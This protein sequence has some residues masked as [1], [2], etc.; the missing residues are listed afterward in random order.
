V[1]SSESA[2]GSITRYCGHCGQCL[3]LPTHDL[4]RSFRCPRCQAV[5]VAGA[6]IDP[7]TPI[8]AVPASDRMPMAAEVVVESP[9][10]TPKAA[11]DGNVAARL[12]GGAALA[13]LTAGRLVTLADRIDSFLYGKRLRL[14]VVAAAAVVGTASLSDGELGWLAPLAL[15]AFVA[16]GAVLTLAR[17]AMFRDD[18]GRWAPAAGWFNFICAVTELGDNV[19]LLLTATVAQRLQAAGTCLIGSSLVVLALR[20]LLDRIYASGLDSW[21]FDWSASWD[22]GGLVLGAGLWLKGTWTRRLDGERAALI[23]DPVK[24]PGRAS[25][26]ASA[27][28]ELPEVIDCRRGQLSTPVGLGIPLLEELIGVLRDWR[29]R[30]EQDEKRYQYLLHRRLCQRVPN[31]DP[32]REVPLRSQGLP[33]TGKID[34]L[35]GHCILIEMKVRLTTSTAQKAS[36]QIGMYVRLWEGKGPLVLVLCDTDH[37]F[38]ASFFGPEIARLR[39]GGHSVVAVTV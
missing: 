21:D 28:A 37:D 36:G 11:N 23:A 17:V 13:A 34:I 22:Y 32:L 1:A 16:L 14:L 39:Q 6:L 8:A 9:R 24:D 18:D 25:Q 10:T 3:V 2:V 15:S 4:A 35:F 26:V 33:Y 7:S 19:R 30:R 12:A 31:A 5:H 38:A 20:V 27:F 29:P